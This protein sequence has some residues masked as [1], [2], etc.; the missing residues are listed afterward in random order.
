MRQGAAHSGAVP[1]R[2]WLGLLV[3]VV[4]W[5]S[6]YALI[7]NALEVLNPLRITAL[8]LVL[9]AALLG[10]IFALRG[11]RLPRGT[12]VWVRLVAVSLCGHGL[13]FF[14]I[15]WGQTLIDSALAGILNAFMPLSVLV[16]ARLL[17]P[18]EHLSRGQALGFVIG[19]VGV[20]MLLAPT[21]GWP[22]RGALAGQLAVLAGAASYGLA[23]V[24]ARG[25]PPLDP[26]VSSLIV[27]VLAAA[28]MLPADLI[29]TPAGQ[30]WWPGWNLALASVVFLG[31]GSTALASVV[32]FYVL[33]ETSAA[34]VATM[35]YLIP[36][37]AA[38]LGALVLGEAL[39]VTAWPALALVLSGI[40]I[41]QG[42]GGRAA[43][44]VAAARRSST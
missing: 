38:L 5:G 37:W 22:P 9:A 4:V 34:F 35:N 36:V 7:E 29:L 30:P 39:P 14:L 32:Y 15:S 43:R 13:P 24:L 10:V 1:L 28:V 16:C 44:L 11:S 8:R 31:L 20:V 41:A 12:R 23:V 26:S 2:Y 3:L 33:R 40:A 42:G 17:L 25:L 21:L 6:S 19:F 18:N 27:V